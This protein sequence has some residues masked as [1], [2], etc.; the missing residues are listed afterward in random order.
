MKIIVKRIQ[1][2]TELYIDRETH[3]EVI[4][5]KTIDLCN[6]ASALTKFS[7][8]SRTKEEYDYPDSDTD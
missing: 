7:L 6:I 1:D 5:M 3:Q 8:S 2:Q 4:C